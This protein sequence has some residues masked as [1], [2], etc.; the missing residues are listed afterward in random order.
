MKC[1]FLNISFSDLPVASV[2]FQSASHET[3]DPFISSQK[4]AERNKQYD[5]FWFSFNP[6]ALTLHEMQ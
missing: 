4:L 5:D 6:L 3:C 2:F 1:G